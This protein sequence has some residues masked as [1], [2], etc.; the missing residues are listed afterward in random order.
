[1]PSLPAPL[2]GLPLTSSERLL[3]LGAL[4]YLALGL[5]CLSFTGIS[6]T[7][8]RLHRR[9]IGTSPTARLATSSGRPGGSTPAYGEG[10]LRSRLCP[11]GA[12]LPPAGRRA[13]PAAQNAGSGSGPSRLD[14]TGRSRV[15]SREVTRPDG[16]TVVLLFCLRRQYRFS[17]GRWHRP[18]G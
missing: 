1:M 7:W 2:P 12:P 5:A 6:N 10:D 11:L 8:S 14:L 15:R 18:R 9:E 4:C 3:L 13:G 16:P 17:G